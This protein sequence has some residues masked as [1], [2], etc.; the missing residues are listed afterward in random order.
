MRTH[1][2]GMA[3][4]SLVLGICWLGGLGSLLAVIFGHVSRHDAKTA[5]MQPPGMATAGLVLGYAGLAVIVILVIV[6]AAVAASHNLSPT[7]E[8]INCTNDQVAG[9]PLPGYC[10]SVGVG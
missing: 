3:V 5:G 2:D 8:F 6:I 1:S 4:A 9:T 10:A 7:Q